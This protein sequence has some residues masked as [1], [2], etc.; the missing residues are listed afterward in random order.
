MQR[1]ALVA[2]VFLII[3]LLMVFGF[4]A[5][6]QAVA[7]VKVTAGLRDGP[8]ELIPLGTSQIWQIEATV[9]NGATSESLDKVHWR[10]NTGEGIDFEGLVSVGCGV[11]TEGPD[12]KN[13]ATRQLNWAIG[14]MGVNQ[15]CVLRFLV[16][17]KSGPPQEFTTSGEHCL[18]VGA[19]VRFLNSAG[20]QEA[21]VGPPIC[22][23]TV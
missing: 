11:F 23:T 21:R 3:G 19:I 20:E 17:T 12:P 10:D 7:V 2:G 18:I 1:A 6:A 13:P 4:S 8:T 15:T 14:A 5:P 22:V 9:G 16:R